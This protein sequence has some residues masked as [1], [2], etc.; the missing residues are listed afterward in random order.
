M[1]NKILEFYLLLT[2]LVCV[3]VLILYM[4]ILSSDIIAVIKPSL[5]TKYDDQIYANNESYYKAKLTKEKK[6]FKDYE[7]KDLT[8]QRNKDSQNELYKIKLNAKKDIA[9]RIPAII[10]VTIFFILH[11]IQYFRIFNQRY[12]VKSDN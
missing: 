9:K 2:C 5:S 10:F 3:M 7:E 11:L 4:A 6:L 8:D 12:R 1:K